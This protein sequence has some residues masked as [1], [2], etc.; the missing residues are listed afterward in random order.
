MREYLRLKSMYVFIACVVLS[1]FTASLF[2]QS[3]NGSIS[4]Y[5]RDPSGAVIPNAH[6]VIKSEATNAEHEATT[7]AGGHYVVTNLQ[8]GLYTMTADA[9]GFK[10]F[11]STTNKLNANS[12]LL[13]NAELAVGQAT[14][15]IEVSATASQ[16]QTESGAVQK[17]VT[18]QQIQAQ[19]L[20]GRNP[21]FM[22]SLIPGVRSG[23]TLGDFSFNLTNG[24]Y[25]I[26]G[27]RSQDTLITIDGAPATR[28][29][30]NGTGITVPNVDATQ[31]I[32]VLT[33]D[34]QAEYGRTSGGQIRVVT[35]SGTTDFHGAASEYFR[36][37]AMNA[38]TW[39][40]NL[41]KT[42]NFASPFRYNDFGF[43]IGGPVAIPHVWE[44]WRQKFFWFVAEEWTRYRF[45]DTQEQTVPTALMRQ[46]NFSELLGPN[47]FYS[48]VKQIYDPATCPKPGAASCAPFAGNII[49]ANRLSRNGLA[50]LNTY[51]AAIP[52]FLDGTKN[53]VARLHTR[54]INGRER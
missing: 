19:E 27:T 33:A 25:N 17:N 11:Q 23:S 34:Y 28:T 1:F 47:I 21:I 2:A 36:N 16:L 4:G 35:K 53:W 32:Q 18:S 26:N 15:T 22:A 31:E 5:V 39:S 24:G 42:T 43:D 51:P 52:G 54:S 7:D 48:G 12:A 29:R 37:S 50:I 8:P 14:E 3:D 40:R 13:L 46:G 30:A 38:N 41:S 6:V 45:T 9:G 44:K 20:N 10:K 49:P